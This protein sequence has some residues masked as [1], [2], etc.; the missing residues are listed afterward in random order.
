MNL[1]HPLRLVP[2]LRA[3]LSPVAGRALRLMVWSWA[4]S[5]LTVSQV[6]ADGSTVSPAGADTIRVLLLTGEHNHNWRFTSRLHADTL[7]AT[8]RFAVDISDDPSAALEDSAGLARYALIVL[9][10]NGRLWSEKARENFVEAVRR[11]TGVVIIHAANNAFP[12]WAQYEAICGLVW[13]AGAGHGS[14]HA[15]DVRYVAS[16]H[17]V[18][19]GLADM[20]AHPDELYHGLSNPQGVSFDVLAVADSRT[21]RGGS[22]RTE[23]VAI[24]SNVGRGRVFHTTLGHVWEGEHAQKVSVCD[25]QF[26]VLLARGAE[27]AATGQVTLGD[28]WH[29]VRRHNVLTPEEIQAGWELLFDGTSPEHFRGFRRADFPSQGW[30]VEEGTLRHVAG[31]G[32]GDIITRRIFADFEFACE[33]KVAPGGNS[34]IM[35]RCTEAGS[36]TWATGPEM[37]ILDNGAHPDARRAATSAGAL[38]GLIPCAHDVIRPA[39]EWNAV[40]IVARGNRIQH[41]VNGFLVVEYEIGGQ[42]WE[43]LIRGTKFETMP[44]FGQAAR[45]HIALQDH[46]DDVWFRNIRIREI[47]R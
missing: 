13:R 23:P 35:Y 3:C 44:G 33:W 21:D 14:F 40:R 10:Y 20:R 22:G 18:T 5:S 15:F 28:H 17:P 29:D 6:C 43:R 45:G 26:R 8:G 31:A 30:V 11:G 12:D 38:Y 16:E 47:R 4:W 7:R 19:R 2:T 37:Q 1:R 34:G 27:W 9:D 42:A 32:G 25:P 46:G 36:A 39:G 41:W 24:A